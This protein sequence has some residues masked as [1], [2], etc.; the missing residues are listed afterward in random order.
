MRDDD[1]RLADIIEACEHLIRHVGSDLQRLRD[2]PV[3]RAAAH[4]WLEIIGEASSQLSE[5]RKELHPSVAWREL[6]GM[7]NILA[8]GYFH[9]D[10]NVVRLSITRDVPALLA[11]LR[12]GD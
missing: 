7:R 6:I 11:A 2:D 9:V 3:A 4:R 1:A 12:P 5:E 10:D 8:H